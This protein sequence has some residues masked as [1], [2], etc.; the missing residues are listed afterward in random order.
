MNIFNNRFLLK[1]SK[2][3]VFYN[4]ENIK[5][6]NEEKLVH[7]FLTEGVS[8]VPVIKKG[9]IVLGVISRKKYFFSK[10]K[11]EVFNVGKITKPPVIVN[12]DDDLAFTL[13]KLKNNSSLIL[14][15]N[16]I[17]ERFISS[18]VVL[19]AFEDYSKKFMVIEKSEKLIRNYINENSPDYIKILEEKNQHKING[20][21]KTIEDLFFSDYNLIFSK[22]WDTLTI[23]DVS[24]KNKFMRDLTETNRIRNSLF[25]FRKNEDLDKLG[26]KPI[27][28]IISVLE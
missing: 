22:R 26:W 20:K 12:L 8:Y 27:E 11:N 23:K 5:D 10:L 2:K 25:H 7:L 17:P 28:D 19:D 13:S 4:A 6:V 16:G 14:L 21:I 24:N 15:I 9:E 1:F 3:L 18:K